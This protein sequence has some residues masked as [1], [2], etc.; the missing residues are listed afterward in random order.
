MKQR[1][2]PSIT[3]MFAG[4]RM[5]KKKIEGK[6]KSMPALPKLRFTKS[7]FKN[8]EKAKILTQLQHDI[9]KEQLEKCTEKSNPI[10]IARLAT[11][12]DKVVPKKEEKINEKE[13]KRN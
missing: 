13:N 2:N 11:L 8:F 9:I 10:Y 7:L 1:N 6:I 12:L 5:S 4:F 3:K